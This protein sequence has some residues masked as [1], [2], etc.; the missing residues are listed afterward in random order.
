M[1][2]RRI[3]MRAGLLIATVSIVENRRRD[4]GN[5]ERGTRNAE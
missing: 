1:S 4:R 3:M 5:D 2:A